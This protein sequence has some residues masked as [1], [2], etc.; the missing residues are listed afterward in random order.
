MIL[1]IAR[2]AS[3]LSDIKAQYR[4][5]DRVDDNRSILM[6]FSS[7]RS[8]YSTFGLSIDS[9][10]LG[11]IAIDSIDLIDFGIVHTGVGGGS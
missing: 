6:E 11:C 7:A 8:T 4:E 5:I 10:R 9:A 2:L 1:T 3:A